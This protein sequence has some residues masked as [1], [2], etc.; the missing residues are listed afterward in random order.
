MFDSAQELNRERVKKL[1]RYAA[2]QKGLV[3]ALA[4]MAIR[5]YDSKCHEHLWQELTKLYGKNPAETTLKEFFCPA[6]EKAFCK[7]AGKELTEKLPYLVQM[8]LE[9]PFSRSPYRRSYRS[10]YFGYYV[11]DLTYL[12]GRIIQEAYYDGSIKERLQYRGTE[13]YEYLLALELRRKEPEVVGLVREAIM[14]ENRNLLLSRAMINAVVISGNEELLEDLIKLL[15]AAKLQEGLRQQILE[16]ADL[17]SRETLEKLLKVVLQEDLLRYSAGIRAFGTWSGMGYG[18]EKPEGVKK[19][20]Q[21]AYDCLTQE[22]KRKEL[23]HSPN[24]VEAY[25]A[26]WAMGC[27]EAQEL[28]TQLPQL[29]QAQEQYRRVLGWFFVSHTDN[30]Y[31]RGQLAF[32]HLQ[33]RDPELLA[34]ITGCLPKTVLLTFCYYE[35]KESRLCKPIPNPFLPGTV[36]ERRRLF[37]ELRELALWIGKKKRVFQG[38]PFPFSAVTLTVEPVTD[39]MMSLAGYDMDRELTEAL[40]AF[41]PNLTA[42]QRQG[43]ICSFLKPTKEE[44]HRSYLLDCLWDRS[45]S[46]RELAVT[47]L[48]DCPLREGELALLADSLRSKSSSFRGGVMA[49]FR[50]QN[51][52]VLQSL[53]PKLLEAQEENQNQ[54]AIE[55]LLELGEAHPHILEGAKAALEALSRR[56]LS[57]QTRILLDQLRQED[58]TE[59]YTRE[60]GFGLYDPAV[61][62]D[63]CRSMEEPSAPSGV[64]SRLFG[65]GKKELLSP[66]ELRQLLPTEEELQALLGRLDQV[67]TRHADYELEC[68]SHD[69]SKCKLLFG[70]VSRYSVPLPA[71][72]GCRGLGDPKATWEMLPFREEFMEAFG[73]YATDLDRM[74]GLYMIFSSYY[75]PGYGKYAFWASSLKKLGLTDDVNGIHREYPRL[76]QFRS[77]VEKLPELFDSHI[78][79]DR[80]IELYRSLVELIGRERL[81]KH[82]LEKEGFSGFQAYGIRKA[83]V[84]INLRELGVLRELV[85]KL[86]PGKEE[87]ARWFCLM[88]PMEQRTKVPVELGLGTKDYFRA[89]EE[90][91]IPED[92][93]YA[94]FLNDYSAMGY[95]ISRLTGRW[96]KDETEE[97]FR[98]YPFAEAMATRLVDRLVAVEERRGEL[99]TELTEHCREI[100]R[101]EGVEHFCRLLGALGKES[102]FRGYEYS[103]DRSKKAVLS[104]LLKRCYPAKEDSVESL[105]VAWEKTKLPQSRLVEA[106]MY[107]PQWAGPAEELLGWKGLKCGVWFFHAH[108]NEGFSAEKETETA[109]YSPISP[110]QFNDGAFDRQWFFRAYGELGEA[111][112]RQLYRC[113]KYITSGSNQ[114]RR[115]QLYTDAVLGKLDAEELLQ[116]IKEKRNQEK[117]RCYPLI[118]IAEGDRQEALRRYE[119]IQNFLKESKQFGAQRRES[120][121]KA[122][123][124]ALENLAITTGL[125]DV[126]RLMWQ[127]ESQKLQELRPYM[128]PVEVE[129]YE[130]SLSIGAEGDASVAVQ[131][132]GKPLKT[133]PKALSKEPLYLELKEKVTELKALRARSGESLERAMTEGTSFGAMEL[134]T[135]AQNPVLAPM[136]EKLLWTDGAHLGF[137]K[138]E[139]GSVLL[140]PLEGEAVSVQELR[141]AHPHDLRSMGLWRAYMS[142]LYEKRMVQPFK[143]V[144]R[145]YYPI[146]AEERQERMLSRR[147]EGHQVQP[148]RTLAL[149]KGRGWT[150]DYES[151][152]QKVFYKENLVVRLYAMADWFSPA[153]IEA[154]TLETVE[155]FDRNTG[156]NVPLEEVPPILFSETMRDLDLVVSVA[157][158][159]GV[160]PEASH[161]TVEMRQA[162]AM[163]LVRLLKLSNVS[164]VGSHARIKGTLA[165]YSVHLGSGVVHGEGI[166]MIP[167]IPVH[168]QARGRIFL[169]FADEDPKTA[170]V[171]SKLLLFAEDHKLKDPTI[172]SQIGKRDK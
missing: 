142:A 120:E 153:D 94:Y 37:Y 78:I 101:V 30:S 145:E 77:L 85:K 84:G 5:T 43:L 52:A 2:E 64:F 61:V 15:R 131:K 23:L 7:L 160:D 97:L 47:W 95:K 117:L 139:G 32:Q 67:F 108:V 167:V 65:K 141:I 96:R 102:F 36:E 57:A 71:H 168:S 92:V 155:F 121:K 88:Y 99:P 50:R 66:K 39:C 136:V 149:L 54:A 34:W 140:L 150:V 86:K 68:L 172:L 81:G 11:S 79:L 104:G 156:E 125:M 9:G 126:N 20:G 72:S 124:T 18:D 45:L 89:Y 118:P 24:N 158:V 46:V 169:P 44:S 56:E 60:N 122:G 103:Y 69:G 146:T 28:L 147:Y 133:V 13:G 76:W 134:L 157:H 80:V 27:H 49:L 127:M 29:L 113:A 143:Q 75:E 33:E 14:G 114:H 74:L 151:G 55:L 3:S 170:E 70:D 112:F 93:V 82:Y 41:A 154:P 16:A 1:Q 58:Q 135:I 105:A 144:F 25:F 40:I 31:F 38:N 130:L 109:L 90:G 106:V 165:N 148:K 8:F 98:R 119:F 161:S 100:S 132:Q 152:L 87:F 171:L 59:L 110:K 12:L 22:R 163:E 42:D 115:S 26:L 128:E 35:A 4:A 83:A 51:L 111:R 137:L 21:L 73:S 62:E 10:K 129:G 107:A 91:V 48:S 6:L 53:I 164:W 138:E 162:V 159:G 116:E 17:G 123:A 166:G 19:L 63:C